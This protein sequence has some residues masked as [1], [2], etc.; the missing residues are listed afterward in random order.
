MLL[1]YATL[2]PASLRYNSETLDLVTARKV[3]GPHSLGVVAVNRDSH[4]PRDRSSCKKGPRPSLI[5]SAC[6][7]NGSLANFRILT[8]RLNRTNTE[9]LEKLIVAVYIVTLRGDL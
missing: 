9:Y 4:G 2:P 7:H 6:V 8:A 3:M 5:I 1:Y